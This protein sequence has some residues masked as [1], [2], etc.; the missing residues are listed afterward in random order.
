MV[1]VGK[2]LQEDAQMVSSFI[3]PLPQ[4]E[5]RR[6]LNYRH[7]QLVKAECW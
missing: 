6:V 4:A 5:K 1:R 2:K 7:V 3:Q